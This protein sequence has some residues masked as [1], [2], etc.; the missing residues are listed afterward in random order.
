MCLQ[1]VFKLQKMGDSSKSTFLRQVDK[2]PAPYCYLRATLEYEGKGLETNALQ[3]KHFVIRALTQVFGQIGASDTIDLLQLSPSGEAILRV[4][5]RC[6]VRL[7]G[8]LA[9]FGKYNDQGCAFRVQQM[10]S[11]LMGISSN[12]RTWDIPQL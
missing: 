10:A 3:F 4:P 6:F 1:N 12:S 8:S 11:S 7:C 2:S 5:S 9:L